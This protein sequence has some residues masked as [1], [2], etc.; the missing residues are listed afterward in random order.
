VAGRPPPCRDRD[1]GLQLSGLAGAA[2][3]TRSPSAGSPARAVFPLGQIRGGLP[4]QRSI[5]RSPGG[6]ATKPSKGG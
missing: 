6:S 2:A 3:A 5:V 1:A 4:C